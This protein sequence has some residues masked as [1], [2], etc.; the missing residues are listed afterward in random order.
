MRPADMPKADFDFEEALAK[1]NKADLQQEQVGNYPAIAASGVLRVGVLIVNRLPD[2]PK[3]S[4]L[5]AQVM[6]L[7]EA[8]Q[9]PSRLLPSRNLE[10]LWL[11]RLQEE[12]QEAEKE[13]AA[14]VYEKDDF[15]D[16]L[17]CEA[18]E[19]LAIKEAG[20]DARADGRARNSAQRKVWLQWLCSLCFAQTA[21]NA[22]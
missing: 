1:F 12:E 7:C 14:K 6:R 21:G 19:R 2:P 8:D 15:F 20:E 4:V 10:I 13:P 9:T 3:W 18:L 5:I 16:S 11:L 17:S 22:G